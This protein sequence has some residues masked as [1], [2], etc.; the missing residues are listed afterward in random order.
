MRRII[1]FIFIFVQSIILLHAQT[2]MMKEL[3]DTIKGEGTVV[4][5]QDAR[6]DSIINGDIIVPS[7]EERRS[8]NTGAKSTNTST[9]STHSRSNKVM[10]TKQTA[11]GS[12]ADMI[13][14]FSKHSSK[15]TGRKVK[16]YRVQVFF[17]GSTRADQTK[18]LQMA[19]KL[20][21]RYGG[22]RTYVSFQSPHWVCRMGD[23]TA[24]EKADN[25]AS[26]LRTTGI[27]QSAMVVR[28]EVYE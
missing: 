8:N 9:Y 13:D 4:V 23:F 27:A 14:N 5:V 20:N 21:G 22:Q 17:G 18:A 16:G 3:Q 28:S 6:L 25:L 12:S 11:M 1:V 26:R 19:Q 7:E 10:Q 24:K 15:T 2:P